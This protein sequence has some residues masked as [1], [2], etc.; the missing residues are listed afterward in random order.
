MRAF[1]EEIGIISSSA[2][3]GLNPVS[4]FLISNSSS[5]DSFSISFPGSCNP[6]GDETE[7]CDGRRRFAIS[8][9]SDRKYE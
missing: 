1:E 7:A 8:L 4:L 2:V 3:H 5:D 9:S 6:F